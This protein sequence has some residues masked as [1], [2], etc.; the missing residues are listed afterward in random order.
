MAITDQRETLVDG[1]T[2]KQLLIEWAGMP[3][4]EATWADA[5]EVHACFRVSTLRIRLCLNR[6]VLIWIQMRWVKE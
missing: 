1:K 2:R 4:E 5:E 6:E 3:R